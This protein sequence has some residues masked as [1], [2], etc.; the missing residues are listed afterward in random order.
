M[1][2]ITIVDGGIVEKAVDDKAV[3]DR[4]LTHGDAPIP[5]EKARLLPHLRVRTTHR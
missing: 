3:T 1:V 4:R 2:V 5:I